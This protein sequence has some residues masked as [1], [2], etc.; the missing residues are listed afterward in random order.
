MKKIFRKNEYEI[1]KMIT[2][3]KR[4][5]ILLLYDAFARRGDILLYPRYDI[6][7][8]N[9]TLKR[10]EDAGLIKMRENIVTI[11]DGIR[12]KGMMHMT[13]KRREKYA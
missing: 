5:H 9:L 10:F 4:I 3:K 12:A 2:E 11:Q 13:E 6:H 7:P 1:I 8:V